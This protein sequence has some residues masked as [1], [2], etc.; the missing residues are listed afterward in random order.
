MVDKI[1]NFIL[2][3]RSN[4]ILSIETDTTRYSVTGTIDTIEAGSEFSGTNYTTVSKHRD[5]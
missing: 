4:N 3:M 5:A 2:C 1:S